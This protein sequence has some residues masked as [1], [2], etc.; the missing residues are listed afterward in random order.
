MP[1]F[2]RIV[3]VLSLAAC[4]GSGSDP[5]IHGAIERDCQHVADKYC[6]D[7]NDFDSCHS[8]TK[9]ITCV[10]IQSGAGCPNGLCIRSSVDFGA[11]NSAMNALPSA[12]KPCH[13]HPV[14]G[15]C[16]ELPD[17]CVSAGCTGATDCPQDNDQWS[18]QP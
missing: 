5:L 11:C 9:F 10:L 14:S 18:G 8:S 12:Y 13:D 4:G 16:V 17:V 7:A 3:F 15:S 6:E 2:A 1:L